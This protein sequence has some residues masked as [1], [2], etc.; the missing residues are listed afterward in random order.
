MKA[1]KLVSKILV[2]VF[3][4]LFGVIFVCGGWAKEHINEITAYLGQPSYEIIGNAGDDYEEEDTIYYDSD[5]TSIAEL[6]AAGEEIAEEVSLEGSAL[7]KN[8]DVGGK[9]ALP[10]SEGD[11]VNFYSMSSYDPIYN[12]TGDQGRAYMNLEYTETHMLDAFTEAGFKVNKDLFDWYRKNY[13]TY[14]RKDSD[15]TLR[16][17]GNAIYKHY[18]IADASWENIGTAAKENAAEA[19]IF[20]LSR[21][22]GEGSD[23]TTHDVGWNPGDMTNGNYLALS[24]TEISVLTNMKRMKDEGKLK[25]IIV[26]LNFS[27]QVECKFIDEEKYVV[28]AAI[29]VGNFGMR[30]PEALAEA[31][32]MPNRDSEI[33]AVTSASF[34]QPFTP[35]CSY[36][37]LSSYSE[38]DENGIRTIQYD[39]GSQKNGAFEHVQTEAGYWATRYVMDTKQDIGI[40]NGPD[41][42]HKNDG[43]HSDLMN[44]CPYSD[45]VE[46]VIMMNFTNNSEEAITILYGV[47]CFGIRGEVTVTLDPGETESALLKQLYAPDGKSGDVAFHVLCILDGGES[48]YDL[49][50]WGFLAE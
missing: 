43:V 29:W 16:A 47:E 28:D 20:I 25:K 24:P 41:E 40:L 46:K 19:G 27:N 48:G 45:E 39:N 3:A 1:L 2:I 13:N 7:L 44:D 15:K 17:W 14:G 5:F 22:A 4:F 33:L 30:G 21:V 9:P 11:T 37:H 6:K 12:G 26:V 10:L 8:G 34:T 23:T 38:P 35:A 42:E 18:T 50:I 31:F 36:K 32:S 49:T